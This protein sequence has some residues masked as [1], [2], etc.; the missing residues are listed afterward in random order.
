MSIP[1]KIPTKKGSKG[2]KSTEIMDQK[3]VTVQ[4]SF[5]VFDTF[6][7]CRSWP[8]KPGSSEFIF[9]KAG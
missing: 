7:M 9:S 6:G 3:K 5:K 8:M 4:N 2:L 1:D